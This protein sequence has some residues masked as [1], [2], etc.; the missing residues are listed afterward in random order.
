MRS[1][2]V[3]RKPKLSSPA[4]IVGWAQD[5]GKLGVKVIDYLNSQL[6]C[7]LLAEIEPLDFFSLSGV[8]VEEDTARF[9]ESKFYFS[10]EKNL[11]LLRSEMPTTEWYS[12]L[13]TVLDVAERC[14]DVK[15]VYSLG[16][17]FSFGAHSTPREMLAIA[18]SE[19]MKQVLHQYDLASDMNFQSPPGQRPTFSS[20]LLWVAKRRG[21]A[22]AG[23][24][25]TVPFYL[26]AVEDPQS[27]KKTLEFLNERLDL[28][29]D[30]GDLDEEIKEQND[31]LAQARCDSP[32]IDSCLRRVENNLGLSEHEIETL[33]SKIEKY[34]RKRD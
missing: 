28:G 25:T 23:L 19:E 1:V 34:V 8:V 7:Q 16:G 2:T 26:A 9:P 30:W 27:S 3:H 5:A 12:F 18:N 24:W 22:A 13:N 32:E 10:R 15:E 33:A 6:G 14:G 4:M 17:M 20:F 21:I 11:V 29:V 31:K